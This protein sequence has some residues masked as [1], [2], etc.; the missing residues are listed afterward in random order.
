[1][2]IIAGEFRGRRLKT[3][4][5]KQ[6][7][8][9]SDRVREAVFSIL[10]QHVRGA[11][12][13]DLFAGTG[14]L[15]LEALSRG[16]ESVV[17]VEQNRET[18]QILRSNL[19]RCA[20]RQKSCVLQQ[21]VLRALGTL[22]RQGARFDLVFMDPPYAKGFPDK[23]LPLLVRLTPYRARVVIEQGAGETLAIDASHWA[24]TGHRRYGDTA[25]T[26]L[27]RWMS[28]EDTESVL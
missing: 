4:K 6:V 22:S 26:F 9:T 27:M 20:V 3:P 18:A 16:A 24:L 15:G 25:V 28:P 17:F 14:A 12:V 8:P 10:A 23:I 11:R 1:L 19:T 5:G 7:R 13:L 21:D 2:R